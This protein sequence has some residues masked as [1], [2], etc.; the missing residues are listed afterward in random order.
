MR[1]SVKHPGM[2]MRRGK[3]HLQLSWPP[4]ETEHLSPVGTTAI[5]AAHQSRYSFL[6]RSLLALAGWH[7]G[8]D[9]SAT[10]AA[11]ECILKE[12]HLSLQHEA[13]LKYL[14]NCISR[15]LVSSVIL[16]HAF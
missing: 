8:R 13:G 5:S 3:C 10:E 1:L 15:E 11:V 16:F 12:A 9:E 4:P 7:A 2:W 6:S 14:D